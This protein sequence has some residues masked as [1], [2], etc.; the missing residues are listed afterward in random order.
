MALVAG[1]LAACAPASPSP[2]T[3]TA[4]P[5]PVAAES[6]AVGSAPAGSAPSGSAAVASIVACPTLAAG[7]APAVPAAPA[8]P[9]ALGQPRWWAGRVFYEVFVRSFADSNGDGIG[10]LRGLTAHLDALN[11]GDPATTTDLGI[12]GIWLMPIAELPS[13]HGYD[14]SDERAVERDYGTLADLTAFINAAHARGIA[15]ISDLVLNH[16]SSQN[17]WFVDSAA[18]TGHRDWYIWSDTNPGYGGPDGQVVW[19]PSGGRWYYGLFGAGLPDLNLA[20][21]EV[22]AELDSIARFWLRDVGL[23]GFRL[24]AIKH[25]IEEGRTQAHTAATHA[26]LQGF[27]DRIHAF[28]PNALLVGEV[29]DLSVA[30]ARYV[31]EDVDLAFDFERAQATIDSIRRGDGGPLNATL[32]EDMTL[33]GPDDTAGFL[34][35]HDQDRIASQLREDPASLRLAAGLLLSGGGTPFVYYGEEIGLTGSKPDEDIRTP[36]PWTGAG[37]AGGFTTGTPWEPL[38][39]GWET[40]NVAAQI[41][42]SDLAPGRLPRPDPAPGIAAGDGCRPDDPPDCVGP[43]GGC[44]AARDRLHRRFPAEP[45]G[46]RRQRVGPGGDRPCPRTRIR[47]T[48]RPG[49]RPGPA[50]DVDRRSGDD[51]RHAPQRDRRGRLRRLDPADRAPAAEPH[52]HRAGRLI[53]PCPSTFPPGRLTPSGTR[54]SPIASSGVDASRHRDRSRRGTR[55]PRTPATRAATCSAS[56]TVSTTSPT[57]ASAGST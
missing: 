38:E 33:F 49:P 48:V 47:R 53:Q 44:V 21:P 41:G 54:S 25:L 18:G 30:V 26:W 50:Q 51:R 37:P 24:D 15:V 23:D 57:S 55:A 10:D 2:G 45:R 46:G 17:P 12:T 16:T 8:T 27:R 43:G 20:N 14:V 36:M 52:D 40:R 39:P 3:V 32:A 1:I 29:Y 22:S 4:L 28:A 56:R 19:H 6:G 42:G 35:N 31:P 34:T 7:A 5:S 11:D 13:Y 9:I